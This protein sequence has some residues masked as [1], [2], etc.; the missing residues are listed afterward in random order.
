MGKPNIVHSSISGRPG[1]VAHID[2]LTDYLP[3]VDID[4]SFQSRAR[5]NYSQMVS[6]INSCLRNMNISRFVLVDVEQCYMNAI[7]KRDKEYYKKW[8]DKGVMYLNIDSNNRT[9]TLKLFEKGSIRIPH[10][11][12]PTNDGSNRIFTVDKTND[13]Y[14]TMDKQFRREFDNSLMSLFIVTQATREELS[15][16]FERMNSGEQLNIFEKLNCS[17]STTCEEIRNLTDRL[18]KI[19]D[20]SKLF[21]ET[22][23]NRRKLDGWI[24]HIHYLYTNGINK[25]FTKNV[26]KNWYNYE[27]VSNSTVKN[28]VEDFEKFITKT[29][30]DK[31][32]LF[33]YK[34]VLF[35]L[36]I[37][38]NEQEKLS[39]KLKDDSTIVQYFIDVM[40]IEVN[41]QI[42]RFQ[43]PDHIIKF[44]NDGLSEKKAKEITVKYPFTHLCRG[45]GG[46]TPLRHKAYKS[47]GFDVTKYFRPIDPKPTFSR[48]QKQ[49]I[50]VR[51]NWTD[52]DGDKFIPE[53]LFDGSKDAGHIVAR[54][55]GGKTIPSNGVIE[56]MSK[57][58]GKGDA[59]TK[60]AV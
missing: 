11:D 29:V 48:I 22:E 27:S 60:V 59:E 13:T 33:P 14:K 47:G 9:T 26:H 23:I 58:R 52:S 12:Y 51:D 3:H 40:T 35:D 17:Y 45:E 41:N 34:W 10:G 50:A 55:K 19:F 36:F 57:N 53:T 5:W 8:L 39:K 25:P 44:M 7:T 32:V 15:I 2:Y 42:P 46:N 1:S 4:L 38:M 54:N 24:A 49:G 28:F 20:K 43:F 56:K 6:F 30:G 16:V 31:I 37:L 18:S 21:T